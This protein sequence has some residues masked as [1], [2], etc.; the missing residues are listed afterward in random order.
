MI[1][2]RYAGATLANCSEWPY[3]R[4]GGRGVGGKRRVASLRKPSTCPPIL[5]TVPAVRIAVRPAHP[6][7][8]ADAIPPWRG[9]RPL[10][11][12]VDDL[13]SIRRG[14]SGELF[15]MAVPTGGWAWGGWETSRRHP[16]GSQQPRHQSPKRLPP[17]KFPSVRLVHRRRPTQSRRG[18]RERATL[19]PIHS[20]VPGIE[21]R[22]VHRPQRRPGVIR[23]RVPRGVPAPTLETPVVE[24]QALERKS[25]PTCGLSARRV[26]RIALPFHSAIPKLERVVDPKMERLGP[27][28]GAPQTRRKVQIPDLDGPVG[29][30][31]RKIGA[32][33]ARRSAHDDDF[34]RTVGLVRDFLQP[35]IEPGPLLERPPRQ[36]GPIAPILRLA[37]RV[38]QRIAVPRRVERLQ[39]TPRTFERDRR[40]IRRLLPVRQ[41]LPNRLAEAIQRH[42]EMFPSRGPRG[43]NIKSGPISP[44]RGRPD[45]VI[46]CTVSARSNSSTRATP[47]SPSTARP[48]R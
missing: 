16:H 26:Q 5:E 11:H 18:S 3:P 17:S 13:W 32:H 12:R 41:I 10:V 19:R 8:P 45:S 47:S 31:D 22:S 24:E 21:P 34:E 25:Q 4:V 9:S 14:G 27:R 28:R 48:H 38:P 7:A 39:S 29:R 40:R 36:I 6:P 35:S 37:E 42:D 43:R 33:P 30:C 44:T 20:K 15:R 46:A 1:F 23:D 2:G